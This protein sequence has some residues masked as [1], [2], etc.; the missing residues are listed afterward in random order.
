MYF[1]DNRPKPMTN[2][3][4]LRDTLTTRIVR[5]EQLTV[6]EYARLSTAARADHDRS[7]VAYASGGLVVRTP[8]ARTALTIVE[9]LLDENSGRIGTQSGLL[10]SG[11]AGFGKT[12]LLK[13]IMRPVNAEYEKYRPSAF[14]DGFTP[15]AFTEA[16][17]DG[18]AKHLL[19]NMCHVYG[20]PIAGAETLASIQT[21][22]VDTMNAADTRLLVVDELH[23][24]NAWTTANGDTIDILRSIHNQV[25]AT[26]IYA[27][28]NL[29]GGKLLAGPKGAQITA[30]STSLQMT[31]YAMRKPTLRK[32]WHA[33]VGSFEKALPLV[34]HELGQLAGHADRLADLCDG[35]LGQLSKMLTGLAI[36]RIRS[37]DTD[38][39]I[40]IHDIE[41]RAG[42]VAAAA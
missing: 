22:L 21:R 29:I 19:Q 14:E 24:L 17:A 28:L 36:Q 40:T 33:L 11:A 18:R 4:D 2:R 23:N 15:I 1:T 34:G 3:R 39:T 13:S 5:P 16:P 35:S 26:F 31:H 41:A 25:P 10:V 27:G 32:E 7:R 42:I 12:T 38:E 9:Q 6:T 8:Q 37:S 20:L 30:R